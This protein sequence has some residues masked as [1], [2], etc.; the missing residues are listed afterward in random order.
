MKI[1]VPSDNPTEEEDMSPSPKL[2]LKKLIERSKSPVKKTFV[3]K[4]RVKEAEEKERK[5]KEREELREQ[6]KIAHE[7]ERER[8][9]IQDMYTKKS[10][11]S[12]WLETKK[13]DTS[14]ENAGNDLLDALR[15]RPEL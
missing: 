8:R 15:L 14:S 13:V 7:L 9:R 10:G 5:I 3:E 6:R 4:F 12:I 11:F 1:C 2:K